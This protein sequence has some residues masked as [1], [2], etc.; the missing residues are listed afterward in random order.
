VLVIDETEMLKPGT[1][2]VGGK[3]QSSGTAGRVDNC[4]IGVLP[5]SAA[6]EGHVLLDREL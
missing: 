5:T 3:R 1:N 2:S 6:P 4:Q